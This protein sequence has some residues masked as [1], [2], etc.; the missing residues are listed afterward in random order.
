MML[1]VYQQLAARA[2]TGPAR[3]LAREL[4]LWHDAMVRH[5]RRLAAAGRGPACASDDCPH[6][7]ARGLWDRAVQ[8]FGTDARTLQYLHTAAGGTSIAMRPAQE[9]RVASAAST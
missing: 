8:I 5:E 1:P 6:A 3:E 7:E 9:G 2:G 4:M